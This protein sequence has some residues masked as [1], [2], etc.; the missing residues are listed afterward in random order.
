LTRS[1]GK[2]C[3][4]ESSL[5]LTKNIGRANIFIFCEDLLVVLF[6][7]ISYGERRTVKSLGECMR[8]TPVATVSVTGGSLA[9]SVKGIYGIGYD[10]LLSIKKQSR[11]SK[12]E[13]LPYL[14]NEMRLTLKDLK[15]SMRKE[16]GL[17]LPS[18]NLKIVCFWMGQV[19]VD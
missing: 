4:R 13:P 7:I 11:K 3:R 15:I 17:N 5:S 1:Y 9:I 12:L 8:I 10:I 2:E 14:E 16:L 6:A 19:I 18:Q